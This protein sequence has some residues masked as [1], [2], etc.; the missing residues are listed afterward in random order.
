MYFPLFFD[1]TEKEILVVGAG[2]V[3]GRRIQVLMG[4]VRK[5]RVVAKQISP[6]VRALSLDAAKAASQGS[7]Q[8]ELAEG[9]FQESDLAGA[10]LVLAA[11]DDAGVNRQIYLLAHKK[12]IPVNV[13]TDAGLCDFQFPSVI[14]SG[15]TVIGINASGKDHARVKE[16]RKK[17]EEKIHADGFKSKYQ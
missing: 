4:F 9:A 14:E 8:I 12:K 16:T 17:I 1:L 13:C 2:N 11:T 10:D 7:T 15:Q 5:I 6:A 3:A